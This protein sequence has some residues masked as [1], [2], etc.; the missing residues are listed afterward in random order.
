MET[1]VRLRTGE[2]YEPPPRLP[3]CF[4]S[5]RERR[6]R[7]TERGGVR[8]AVP[9]II[10]EGACACAVTLPVCPCWNTDPRPS[11]APTQS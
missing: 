7:K 3:L 8:T 1:D 5:E 11:L 4:I 2:T 6:E 9:Q 10:Q